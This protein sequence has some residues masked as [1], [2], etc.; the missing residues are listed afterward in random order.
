[1]F[2][3]EIR[4]NRHP[5]IIRSMKA[6][7]QHSFRAIYVGLWVVETWEPLTHAAHLQH[8]QS[9]DARASADPHPQKL[10]LLS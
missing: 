4:V 5:I 1:M 3:K 8:E 9:A 2:R 6:V 7:V 10:C